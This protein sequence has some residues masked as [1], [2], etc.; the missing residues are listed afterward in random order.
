MT[1][2]AL[3]LVVAFAGCGSEETPEPEVPAE[4]P[5]TNTAVHWSVDEW[6]IGGISV[7]SGSE[8]I[9]AIAGIL[10]AEVRVGATSTNIEGG[11][12]GSMA[13]FNN[14]AN[15]FRDIQTARPGVSL[16]RGIVI[17]ETSF[18]EVLTMFPMNDEFPYNIVE[19]GDGA[20]HWRIVE[21]DV[22][23]NFLQHIIDPILTGPDLF[24]PQYSIG[25]SDGVVARVMFTQMST[26][27]DGEEPLE[28]PEPDDAPDVPVDSAPSFTI[29]VVKRDAPANAP[30]YFEVQIISTSFVE[31]GFGMDEIFG[32][33]TVVFELENISGQA[34]TVDLA[35]LFSEG[36]IAAG[37][38]I[39]QDIH[40]EPG[41]IR[42]LTH[43]F[44]EYNLDVST[45]LTLEYWNVR[46]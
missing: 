14:N 9:D 23:I 44:G 24:N 2:I 20:Y 17:G 10:G 43:S 22:S 3:M 15:M 34:V 4:T 11:D 25:F 30:S 46:Y 40:F 31:T 36:Q 38:L 33:Y 16:M 28:A 32:G 37:A 29:T 12:F 1:L 35:S 26:M 27:I 7:F 8:S 18:D 19:S 21:D 41:Q 5:S 45:N 39:D 13:V 6:A 42:Q